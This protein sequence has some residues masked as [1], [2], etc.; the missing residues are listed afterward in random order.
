MTL[1]RLDSKEGVLATFFFRNTRD[2]T[3]LQQERVGIL[4]G[5]PVTDLHHV[6][7]QIVAVQSSE[8]FV[9]AVVFLTSQGVPR[10][11]GFFALVPD[12]LGVS[13]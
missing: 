9:A 11:L 7:K 10:L 1:I 8:A 5:Q 4:G 3:V 13:S 2:R 12:R 6:L